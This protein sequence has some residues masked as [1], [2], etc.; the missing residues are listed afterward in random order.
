MFLPGPQEIPHQCWG[1]LSVAML[2]VST[3]RGELT[4]GDHV[5]WS[6]L[7]C[8]RAVH[9][10]GEAAAAPG[11]HTLHGAGTC[12]CMER[13]WLPWHWSWHREP[14]PALLSLTLQQ[15]DHSPADRWA[16]A[17]LAEPCLVW[18][19]MLPGAISHHGAAAHPSPRS[20]AWRCSLCWDRWSLWSSRSDFI[21]MNLT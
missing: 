1:A 16:E 8:P 5:P 14:Q 9:G 6:W 11:L 4:C 21:N 7:C 19:Q 20:T 12:L 17:A 13:L 3:V 10:T 15:V 2:T 18:G